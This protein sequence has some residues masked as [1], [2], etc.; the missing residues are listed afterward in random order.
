M[1]VDLGLTCHLLNPSECLAQG[2]KCQHQIS[3]ITIL[4]HRIQVVRCKCRVTL[5]HLSRCVF[6]STMCFSHFVSP[7]HLTVL[8]PDQYPAFVIPCRHH[9]SAKSPYFQRERNT[10]G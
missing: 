5:K 10:L 4:Q 3:F 9:M 2:S 7:S 1:G 8:L 6:M